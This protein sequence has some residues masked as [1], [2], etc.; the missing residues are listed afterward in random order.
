MKRLAVFTDG[1]WNDPEDNTNVNDLYQLVSHADPVGV[2]Q[3][4]YYHAGV[5]VSWSTRLRGGAFG[6]GLSDNVLD[7]YRWLVQ[8][9]DADDEIY[10]FGFS[11]GAYT[12]RS[13]AGVIVKCGLVRRD[14]PGAL[15]PDVI[16]ARYRLGKKVVGLYDLTANRLPAGYQLSAD[17]RELLEHSHRVPIKFVGVWGHRG[18]AGYS[19]D[20]CPFFRAW[21]LLLSRY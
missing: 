2:E 6:L 8:N 14:A 21:Q 4:R 20:G 3:R 11:R 5:G 15:T 17:D 16:Y 18:R 19:L 9:Y 1:T 13:V 7:A 12:A 10:L